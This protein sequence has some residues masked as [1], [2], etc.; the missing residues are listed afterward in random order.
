VEV[1]TTAATPTA[2]A[3][4]GGCS[5]FEHHITGDISFAF[6]Q[7]WQTTRDV[8][9][10]REEGQPMLF[11]IAEYWASRVTECEQHAARQGQRQYCVHH[12]MGPDEFHS[13]RN[14]SVF[15]NNVAKLALDAAVSVGLILGIPTPAN[16]STIS[17]EMYFPYARNGTVEDTGG[18]SG[19]SGVYYHPEFDGYK[20]GTKI[21]QADAILMGFPHFRYA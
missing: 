20:V 18:G 17:R 16:W 5:V 10:L 3:R 2:P 4:V 7:H 9:W 6:Y 15:T 1:E 13:D 8:T 14:N 19:S 12:V 11:G 21:K